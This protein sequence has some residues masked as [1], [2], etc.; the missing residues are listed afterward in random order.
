MRP[1]LVLLAVTACTGDIVVPSTLPGT[2]GPSG[3]GS[4]ADPSQPGPGDPMQAPPTP[5]VTEL[6]RLT[7]TELDRTLSLLLGDTTH[8]ALTLMPGEELTPFD[9]DYSKQQASAVWVEAAERLVQQV[10]QAT[11]ASATRKAAILPCTP[12]NDDD[13]ACLAPFI[14]SFGRRALHRP[15][16]D[17]E[18]TEL[19][20]LHAL[21]RQRGTF[22]TSMGL[23][24]QRLLLDPEFLFRVEVGTPGATAGTS[25]LGAYELAARLSFFLLG[26][27]PSDALL[28]AAERGELD[29]PA[30]VRTVAQGLLESSE[31][32]SQLELFHAMW[33]GYLSLP[34]DAMFNARAVNETTALVRK[35]VF[36]DRGDYRGLFTSTQTWVDDTMAEH[37]GLPKSGAAGYRWVDYGSTGRMGI[38]SHA[39]LLSNG[40]KQTDT[41]PTLRGKWIRNRLF[42]QEIAPPPPN[43]VADVPPPETGSAVCKKDR[44]AAHDQVMSCA[45]CHLQMDPIGF[46]LEQFD[47]T[48]AF[49]SA[50][51]A[52]PECEIRGEGALQGV[53]NFVGAKGLAE[54]MVQTSSLD[55]C[56]TRQLFRFGTG[57]RELPTDGALIRDLSQGFAKGGRR[58]DQLVLDY[59]SHPTFAQRQEAP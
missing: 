33:L 18:V 22:T 44:Y 49:R 9:N 1:A 27:A 30:Q 40:V 51:A 23:V 59:V 52:H 19:S 47:R 5:A 21:A 35:V 46:G 4:P 10:T 20:S 56:V 12:A 2:T 28:D 57:R 41:S 8:A 3:P 42:C 37:Y 32:H 55:G 17:A 53:G 38:L 34:H 11:L 54:L 13:L 25:Q 14:K 6:R 7:R 24:M 31:G 26:H 48:G 36:E 45:A 50:E 39:S 16:T 15:I 43:V 29:T 58:F